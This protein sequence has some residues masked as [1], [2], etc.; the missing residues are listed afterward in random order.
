MAV[1]TLSIDGKLVSGREDETI[2]DAA[3][4]AC[5][6]IPT[7]CHLEGVS[8]VGDCRLCLVEVGGRLQAACVT[9]P[10]LEGRQIKL[11]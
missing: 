4:E 6:S 9:T 10:H 7:L 1:K 8:A 2:L 5:A 11:G 3:R